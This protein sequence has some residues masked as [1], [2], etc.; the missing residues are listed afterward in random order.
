M[1]RLKINKSITAM[2]ENVTWSNLT[3]LCLRKYLFWGYFWERKLQRANLTE[4]GNLLVN[5]SSPK[6]TQVRV[7][8]CQG[9]SWHYRELPLEADRGRCADNLRGDSVTCA[10]PSCGLTTTR[11][12]HTEQRHLHDSAKEKWSHECFLAC[13]DCVTCCQW[14]P[15]N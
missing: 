11:Q 2:P 12:R 13:T 8:T 4:W 10:P 14:R 3:Q 6:K 15:C 9:G 1:H 7:G 5:I